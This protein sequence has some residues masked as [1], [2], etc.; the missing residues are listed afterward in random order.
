[1]AEATTSSVAPNQPER[2]STPADEVPGELP[3]QHSCSAERREALRRLSAE[4]GDA[5]P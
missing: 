2:A 3:E 1:M 4:H 5:M